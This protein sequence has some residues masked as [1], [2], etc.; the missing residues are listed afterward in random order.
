MT[1]NKQS[2]F[3]YYFNDFREFMATSHVAFYSLIVMTLP[4]IATAEWDR[5]TA[6]GW[7]AILVG[8][9]TITKRQ[10]EKLN[11]KPI[12]RKVDM[13]YVGYGNNNHITLEGGPY[14]ESQ[15]DEAHTKAAEMTAA[16]GTEYRVFLAET[17]FSTY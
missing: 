4:A 14:L 3:K 8:L 2:G 1:K 16:K 13:Y 6:Y 9:S 7:G 15:L 17:A 11:L 10:R 12:G 5:A